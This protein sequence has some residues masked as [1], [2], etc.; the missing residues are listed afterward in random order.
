MSE[1]LPVKHPWVAYIGLIFGSFTTIEALAFQIPVVPVLR[2]VFGIT[3][4]TAAFIGLVYYL[5]HIVTGPVWGN[6]A[7]QYGRKRIVLTGMAVFAVSEFMA[8]LSPSFPVFL[9]ARL[10]QGIGTGCIVSS[11]L[12]YAQYLFPPEKRGTAMGV[13][14][15]FGTVGAAVGSIVG[16]IVI[17]KFGWQ[18]IYYINGSFAIIGMIIISM[19]VPETQ[20]MAKKVFDYLGAILLLLTVGTLLSV[21]TLMSNKGPSSPITLGVLALGIIFFLLLWQ[22]E[23]RSPNPFI[24]LSLLKNR[25][26]ILPLIIYFFIQISNTGAMMS[27]SFFV[28][29]KPGGGTLAVGTVAMWSYI[30]GAIAAF[31][32]GRLID[33]IR[34]KY[35]LLAGI[36][37]FFCGILM[38]SRCTP[39][40]PLWYIS[41]AVGTFTFGI[42]AMMPACIKMALSIVPSDRLGKGSGTYTMV[43]YLGNP[44]GNSIGLAVFGTLSASTLAAELTTKAQAVGVSTDMIPSVLAAGKTAGKVVDPSLVNYLSNL[45]LT[46]KDIYTAANAQAMAGALNHMSYIILG[47]AVVVFIVTLIALPNI[48]STR[49]KAS[50]EAGK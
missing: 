25:I 38:Y 7:D 35:I 17:T 50:A 20:R 40:T 32:S 30:S 14:S 3:V 45:G 39:D 4:A 6:F 31:V 27:N 9:A 12:A 2:E 37:V 28:N 49:K 5:T 43:Q 48:P 18:S 36:A 26:F 33:Y 29:A 15:A 47:V 8:A 41:A 1:N 16:G 22:V 24:E 46:F 10:L 11:G 13:F 21:T 42:C 19:T 34:I 44:A 23:K